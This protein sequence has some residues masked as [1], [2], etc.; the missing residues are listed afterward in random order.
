MY[1]VWHDSLCRKGWNDTGKQNR[2]LGNRWANQVK[3]GSQYD[4]IQDVV[5]QA[6]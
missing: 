6:C 4:H 3:S 5:D 2:R 1:E